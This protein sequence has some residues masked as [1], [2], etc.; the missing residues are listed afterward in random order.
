[1]Y[2]GLHIKLPLFMSDYKVKFSKNTQIQN[3]MKIHPLEA[4]LLNADGRTDRHDEPKS[5]FEI[6]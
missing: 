3:F 1:M 2:I 4:E 5:L 6:L